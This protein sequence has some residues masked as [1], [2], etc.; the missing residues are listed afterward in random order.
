MGRLPPWGVAWTRT[1][2]ITVVA[3]P[4]DGRVAL[5]GQAVAY[6]NR[7]FAEIGSPFRLGGVTQVSGSIAGEELAVARREPGSAQPHP[8]SSA[9]AYVLLEISLSGSLPTERRQHVQ[10][11]RRRRSR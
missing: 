5:V 1:P 10:D 3:P 4:G 6:W 11:F 2:T 7:I 8:D 9:V